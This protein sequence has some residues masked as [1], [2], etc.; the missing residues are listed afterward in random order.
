MGTAA[1]KSA[2]SVSQIQQTEDNKTIVVGVFGLDDAGKTSIIRAIDGDPTENVP[3]TSSSKTVL[4]MNPLN[5]TTNRTDRTKTK[6]RIQLI[7]VSGDKRYREQSWSQFYDRIHGFI[8]VFDASE[9]RRFRENQDVLADLLEH[10]QLQKKPFL[11]FANKQDQRGAI[12]NEYD[13]KRKLNI[14][15][16]QA[17]YKLELCT[18]LPQDDDNNV[19]ESIQ[20]GFTWLIQSITNN[21]TEL[22][23]R[24]SKTKSKPLSHS[25]SNGNGMNKDTDSHTKIT[26]QKLPDINMNKSKSKTYSDGENEDRPLSNGLLKKK[27]LL[28]TSNNNQSSLQKSR[29]NE[30]KAFRSTYESFPEDTPWS[31]STSVLKSTRSDDILSRFNTRTSLANDSKRRDVSPLV[32]DLK[33]YTNGS[34][35]HKHDNYSDDDEHNNNYSQ[36]SKTTNRPKSSTGVY[37]DDYYSSSSKTTSHTSNRNDY[38]TANSQYRSKSSGNDDYHYTSTKPAVTSR[39]GGDDDNDDDYYSSLKSKYNGGNRSFPP[40]KPVSQSKFEDDDDDDAYYP[41]SSIKATS[42]STYDDGDDDDAYP[43]APRITDH[44][45]SYNNYN[46]YRSRLENESFFTSN[47]GSNSLNRSRKNNY[48]DY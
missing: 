35:S 33:S 41:S 37:N 27:K 4:I 48:Y 46:G 7:D 40:P 26:S 9:K 8:F 30:L 44:S 13:L 19:D 22:N 2:K 24:V 25:L 32:R 16:L 43:S 23:A 36:R 28:G 15:R 34:S 17:K 42:R 5:E 45:S 3:P 14:E 20:Q 31:I 38:S 29:D 18:A 10:D 47:N 1:C 39:Y 11:I 6:Q 21:F 12:N